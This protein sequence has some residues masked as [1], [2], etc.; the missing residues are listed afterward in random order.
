MIGILAL[1]LVIFLW[2]FGFYLYYASQKLH[3]DIYEMQAVGSANHEAVQKY[4]KVIRAT[5][6]K[7]FKT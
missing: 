4:E 7:R 3:E 6:D 1:F 5:T 2:G